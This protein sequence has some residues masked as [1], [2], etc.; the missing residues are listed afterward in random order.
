MQIMMMEM[1]MMMTLMVM[2]MMMMMAMVMKMM[3]MIGKEQ[4]RNVL[5]GFRC[6][7]CCVRT[8]LDTAKHY[9]LNHFCA[10]ERCAQKVLLC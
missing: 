1:M 8:A 5:N 9:G 4:H 10:I 7:E 2:M 3:V 6:D